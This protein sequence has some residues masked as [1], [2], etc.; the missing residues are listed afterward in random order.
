MGFPAIAFQ[1]LMN[2]ISGAD[3]ASGGRTDCRTTQAG[4]A[5]R[6]LRTV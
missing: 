3:N 1:P 2:Y 5:M 6:F 4:A